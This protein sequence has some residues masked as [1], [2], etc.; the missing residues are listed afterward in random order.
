MALVLIEKFRHARRTQG[1]GTALI[2]AVRWLLQQIIRIIT[3]R[4]RLGDRLVAF[5]DFFLYHKRFPSN[6]PIFNDV[7]YTLKTTDEILDPLR[8]F[9]SDKELVKLFVKAVVGDQ[10]NVPTIAVLK[11]SDEVDSFDFPSTCCIKPT[12]ASGHVIL[13]RNGEEINTEIIKKWFSINYYNI[14]REANYKTLKPKVIVEPL[15]FEGEYIKEYRFYCYNGK[16]RFIGVDMDKNSNKFY[17]IDWNELKFSIQLPRSSLT[18]AK[19]KNYYEMLQ[20]ATHLSSRF[21][22]IRVDFYSNGNQ[23]FV[24]E[25]T[26]GHR[27]AAGV[28]IP[29]TSE[30][31]ASQLLFK[32]KL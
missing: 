18:I 4:N 1:I 22:F 11:S 21:S 7:L 14:G 30:T 27:G 6:D 13:R 10:Y 24:G 17:D 29:L 5:V 23:L 26:N 9:V 3:P 20:V 16:P 15:I 28:F 25:L 32:Y 12:Q 8:V 31:I 19:P 2:K